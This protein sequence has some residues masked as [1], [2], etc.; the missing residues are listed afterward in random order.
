MLVAL[1]EFRSPRPSPWIPGLAWSPRSQV[2]E[3]SGARHRLLRIGLLFASS[4]VAAP[5]RSSTALRAKPSR[6]RSRGPLAVWCQKF[7]GPFVQFDIYWGS[8]ARSHHLR[9]VLG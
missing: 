4:R 1:G 2:F 7:L 6:A 9:E 5:K 3:T 8:R